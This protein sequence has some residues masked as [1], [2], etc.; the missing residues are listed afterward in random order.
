MF[1]KEFQANLLRLI[2]EKEMTVESLA[3]ASGLT[4]EFLSRMLS[5]KQVPTITSLEKICSAVEAEPNDL[6]INKKSRKGERAKAVRV[7]TVYCRRQDK[8]YS[9]IPVCPSCNS[10]L[11]NDWQSYCDICGQRLSWE[12]YIDS[13]VTMVKPERKH[14]G[15]DDI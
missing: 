10:L 9:Y 3:R 12:R 7:N 13:K 11:S 1:T 4:R 2:D 8:V 14:L 6:L 15:N 5:G